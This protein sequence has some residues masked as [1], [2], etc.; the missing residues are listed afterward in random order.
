M[1]PSIMTLTK[2]ILSIMLLT[3]M[4]L[5]LKVLSI[6]TLSVMTLSTMKKRKKFA[7]QKMFFGQYKRHHNK[8]EVNGTVQSSL[9]VQTSLDS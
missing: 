3:I 5:S 8:E 9:S 1:T 2:I 6:T 7:D 4:L